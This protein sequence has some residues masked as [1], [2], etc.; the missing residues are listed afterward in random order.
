MRI[1]WDTILITLLITFIILA[2]IPSILQEIK[3]YTDNE[4]VNEIELNVALAKDIAIKQMDLECSEKISTI[5]FGCTEA[6]NKVKENQVKLVETCNKY[7]RKQY[8]L[9]TEL[10]KKIKNPKKKS[11]SKQ[12]WKKP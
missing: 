4:L 2:G 5:T 1:N 6:I 10:S 8:K 11:T 3:K 12:W 7:I 9:N